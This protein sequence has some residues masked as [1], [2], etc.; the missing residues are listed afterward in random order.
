MT[1]FDSFLTEA[2][3]FS[4]K[5]TYCDPD[6]RV[7]KEHEISFTMPG[8]NSTEAAKLALDHLWRKGW[9]IVSMTVTSNKNLPHQRH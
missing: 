2:Q 5:I 7:A 9:D 8:K 3:G 6:D 4:F 1:T